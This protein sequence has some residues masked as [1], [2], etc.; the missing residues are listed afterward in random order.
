MITCIGNGWIINV[1]ANQ[2]YFTPRMFLELHK[3]MNDTLEMLK[4]VG[5]PNKEHKGIFWNIIIK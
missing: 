2:K 3:H 4:H 5:K 1:E